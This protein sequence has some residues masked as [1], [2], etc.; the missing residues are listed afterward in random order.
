[1]MAKASS[2]SKSALGSLARILLLGG[3]TVA[4]IVMLTAVQITHAFLS[5]TGGASGVSAVAIR[6][7]ARTFERYKE[8]RAEIIQ[9]IAK[10]QDQRS[11]ALSLSSDAGVFQY[12]QKVQFRRFIFACYPKA[13]RDTRDLLEK[14]GEEISGLSWDFLL[15]VYQ[16]AAEMPAPPTCPAINRQSTQALAPLRA[17]KLEHDKLFPECDGK[18]APR[19]RLECL[20]N[21]VTF[22][23][24]L[25]EITQQRRRSIEAELQARKVALNDLDSELLSD[26]VFADPAGRAAIAAW[27]E[28]DGGAAP[29]DG[30]VLTVV[31]RAAGRFISLLVTL[32]VLAQSALLALLAGAVGGGVARFWE[33]LGY[34]VFDG[35][36]LDRAS[37]AVSDLADKAKA[38]DY[39]ELIQELAPHLRKLDE[40]R[41]AIDRFH[42]AQVTEAAWPLVTACFSGAG[43]ALILWLLMTSGLFVLSGGDNVSSASPN[44][45]LA[46]SLAAG[47]AHRQVINVIFSLA[48]RFLSRGSGGDK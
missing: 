35:A 1:M 8:R 36:Q 44:V 20:W 34:R 10:F 9:S 15:P 2:G 7:E 3:I 37:K 23:V 38:D 31:N 30:K 11:E 46:I 39:A 21:N 40:A 29:S 5:V 24:G 26:K 14:D 4:M 12:F 45:L 18:A 33:S 22:G 6:D 27:L 41:E 19:D 47:L 43:S 17:S 32:P 16:A 28:L 42:K 13:Q 48:Q 25:E